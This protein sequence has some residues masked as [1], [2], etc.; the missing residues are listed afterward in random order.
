MGAGADK[1]LQ[2]AYTKTLLGTAYTSETEESLV[3]AAHDLAEAEHM[4]FDKALAITSGT[5][6]RPYGSPKNNI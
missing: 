4:P 1:Q 3:E 2:D 5:S 6:R